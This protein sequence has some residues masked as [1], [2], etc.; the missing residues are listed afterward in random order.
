MFA[1]L[2]AISVPFFNPALPNAGYV[3]VAIPTN[4][5]NYRARLEGKAFDPNALVPRVE[6]MMFAQQLAFER[7]VVRDVG[8]SLGPYDG[9]PITVEQRRT[10]GA[11]YVMYNFSAG[12]LNTR[13][14]DGFTAGGGIADMLFYAMYPNVSPWGGFVALSGSVERVSLSVDTQPFQLPEEYGYDAATYLLDGVREDCCFSDDFL[15]SI[16]NTEPKLLLRG[17]M[18]DLCAKGDLMECFGFTSYTAQTNEEETADYEYYHKRWRQ[19]DGP[20]DGWQETNTVS[21]TVT[22]N[23]NGGLWFSVDALRSTVAYYHYNPSDG[24][25]DYYVGDG[26][27]K[28]TK[29][30]NGE[31]IDG[32]TFPLVGDKVYFWD[33]G[34]LGT[35]SPSRV[36]RVTAY[37][38]FYAY[39]GVTDRTSVNGWEDTY[40]EEFEDE[41]YIAVKLTT[42]SPSVEEKVERGD[43]YTN[44]WCEVSYGFQTPNVKS[45]ASDA[46][47]F[48]GMGLPSD[49][50]PD[51][52]AHPAW[53]PGSGEGYDSSA[54]SH[55]TASVELVDLLCIME[56]DFIAT[57]KEPAQSGEEEGTNDNP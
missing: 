14:A 35:A 3:D 49:E 50:S 39:G 34:N 17:Q 53:I 13:T 20:D 55:H 37:G 22:T 6:D 51:Y 5:I 9:N 31:P 36:K 38:I 46:C 48:F 16:T 42:G 52:P 12:A 18:L 15:S 47:S 54:T 26:H 41:C 7:Q 4:P 28:W 29:E 19:G 40:T 2:F 23:A 44:Y 57:M 32:L 30:D 10:S 21:R 45:V 56:F 24:E 1:A 11:E 33:Y 25:I 8:K 43:G 27:V